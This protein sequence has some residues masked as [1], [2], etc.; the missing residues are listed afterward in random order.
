[1]KAVQAERNEAKIGD[2]VQGDEEGNRSSD[3]R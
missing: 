3:S 1:M 2:H